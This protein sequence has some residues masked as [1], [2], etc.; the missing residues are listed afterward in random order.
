MQHA[1]K[2]HFKAN[3][4]SKNLDRP[5][6]ER[7]RELSTCISVGMPSGGSKGQDTRMQFQSRKAGGLVGHQAMITAITSSRVCCYSSL[8][9]SRSRM[10]I[11]F[12]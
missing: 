3:P 2:G 6:S 4:N 5:R 1:V 8:S 11:A 10:C 12:A 9:R 7:V